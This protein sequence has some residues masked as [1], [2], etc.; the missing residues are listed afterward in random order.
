MTLNSAYLKS[1][2]YYVAGALFGVFVLYELV[3]NLSGGSAGGTSPNISGGDKQLAA[4]QA[5]ADL[6]NAQTNAQ[7]TTASIAGSVAT[8]QALFALKATELT[9]AAQLDATNHQTEAARQV[10]LAHEQGA[11]SIQSIITS[12]HLAE[13][14]AEI[15][16]LENIAVT[17]GNTQ[18]AIAETMI[19]PQL[20]MVENIN[21]QVGTIQKYSKHASQ[22]YKAITPVILAETGQGGAAVGVAQANTQEAVAKSPGAVIS[23]ASKGIGTILSGLFG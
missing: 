7:I 9:T 17:S 5:G 6:T 13:T 10:G 12:G 22:D 4:L 21:A 15:A 23:A 20:A 14:Q 19:K 1:H 11:V 2:W 18:K 3:K 16:G 8:N